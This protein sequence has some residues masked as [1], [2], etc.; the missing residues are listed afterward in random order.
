[1]LFSFDA[2]SARGVPTVCV[3][4]VWA[5][6][7]N[8]W[9]QEKPKARKMLLNRAESHT[10]GA[11]FVSCVFC[12]SNTIALGSVAHLII[13]DDVI[14]ARLK[15]CGSFIKLIYLTVIFNTLLSKAF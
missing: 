4:R 3:T 10:S 13:L 14:N 9:E 1:M 15:A 11:R 7:D 12:Y 6:V 8:V 2:H 5:G